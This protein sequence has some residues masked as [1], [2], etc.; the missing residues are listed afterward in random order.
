MTS[1]KQLTLYTAELDRMLAFY[2]NMLGAQHVHEQA[3]AFT[4]QLGVSQIQFRAA[5]DGTK[6]FYHIAINIAANHFQEGKAWLSGFGELLTE[7]DEDQAYFP[8]FNAYSCYVEDPSGNIIEL[9]SRQQAAPVLD[10]PF[11][12]DQL[13]SIGEINIT[14]SDVE[15]AATRLK[16]AELPV[17]LDQIEPAGLNFIGDQDLFLL[18]GPPGRRW[19]FS[20]RVAVIYPLQMELDN[21]V[22]LAITETGELVI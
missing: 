19:L 22:S 10:K 16:Q 15:Q 5:A 13:L 14:T 1:I 20:E 3:D 6:P 9:I 18:L 12:A 8:F 11:S 2:T 4:I 7:N 17:K 21:G